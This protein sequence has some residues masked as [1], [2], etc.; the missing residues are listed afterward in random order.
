MTAG[1]PSHDQQV[2]QVRARQDEDQSH[3]SEQHDR[4]GDEQA[5]DPRVQLYLL[6]IED[7]DAPASVQ[8]GVLIGE[9]SGEGIHC[10]LG[11]RYGDPWR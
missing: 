8:V 7:A 4:C 5:I 10:R 2:C 6:L 1:Q 3:N 9:P 11:L